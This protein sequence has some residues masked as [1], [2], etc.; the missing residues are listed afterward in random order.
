MAS[1]IPKNGINKGWFQKGKPGPWAGKR[2]PEV[3]KWLHTKE[4]VE[5]VS[6]A[7]KGRKY[8]DRQG[9]NTWNYKGED[10]SYR[11]LHRWVERMI[12]KPSKCSQCGII[13]YG[14]KMHWANK[15]GEYR[16]I[17]ADWIRLCAKCHGIYDKKLGL[18]KHIT[19][20]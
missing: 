14:R 6:K 20:I 5:K 7:Q 18:R 13:G 12:G 17:L 1:G 15:S 11:N 19:K 2:R 8:P 4:V 16:R 10:V 3:S 9:E